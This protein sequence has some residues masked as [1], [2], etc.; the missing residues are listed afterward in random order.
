MLVLCKRTY[1]CNKTKNILFTNKKSYNSIFPNRH[2]SS[3]IY[4]WLKDNNNEWC[5]FNK[6]VFE[7]HFEYIEERRNNIINE[8][9][10]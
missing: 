4:I 9:L 1:L 2:E 8:L 5:F 3:I 7:K 10:N 6:E